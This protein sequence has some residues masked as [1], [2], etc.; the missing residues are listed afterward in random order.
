MFDY[1]SNDRR[2]LRKALIGQFEVDFNALLEQQWK[3]LADVSNSE[4][5]ISTDLVSLSGYPC[6]EFCGL[7]LLN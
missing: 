3:T 2:R 5:S 7:E 1:S 6:F 4:S